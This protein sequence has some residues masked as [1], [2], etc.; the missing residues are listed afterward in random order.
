M[1]D[2]VE[3]KYN[4]GQNSNRNTNKMIQLLFKI[5]PEIISV[6]ET[7]LLRFKSDDTISAKGFSASYVIID[8]AENFDYHAPGSLFKNT[9]ATKHKKKENS[10]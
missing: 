6:E 8:E 2:F 1:E 5:P 7:L 4:L 9:R 3:Q 10:F